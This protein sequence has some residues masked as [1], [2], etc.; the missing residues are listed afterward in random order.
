MLLRAQWEIM[1]F[2]RFFFCLKM[3][4]TYGELL[5]VMEKFKRENR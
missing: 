3:G 5:K 4:P 1:Q 2:L